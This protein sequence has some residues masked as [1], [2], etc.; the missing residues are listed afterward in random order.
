M[1]KQGFNDRA[2]GQASLIRYVKKIRLPSLVTGRTSGTYATA[3]AYPLCTVQAGT[4]IHNVTAE[5][6][7]A[8]DSGSPSTSA[9]SIGDGDDD[10]R[11]LDAIIK[12]EID[13]ANETVT[14][15][16][17]GGDTTKDLYTY[18]SNDTIDL[19]ITGALFTAGALDFHIDYT[20]EAADEG[21]VVV[22]TD[23]ASS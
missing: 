6:V 11:Y 22:S 2:S 13:A 1:N 23:N 4:T 15:A 3:T 5:V 17:D 16:N 18:S 12:T 20:S 21:V 10:N 8:A 7:T 19:K 14:W 9:I